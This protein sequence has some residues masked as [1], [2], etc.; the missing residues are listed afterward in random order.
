LSLSLSPGLFVMC[1]AI[2]YTVMRPDGEE[3]AVFGFAYIL[4]WPS[5]PQQPPLTA[6][7]E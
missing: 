7:C 5:S 1:G 4:A 3:D 2:I 6:M